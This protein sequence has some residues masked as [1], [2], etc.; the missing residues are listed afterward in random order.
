[1]AQVGDVFCDQRFSRHSAAYFLQEVV[2]TCIVNAEGV[3]LRRFAAGHVCDFCE[4][5]PIGI[6]GAEVIQPGGIEILKYE[7]IGLDVIVEL[8]VGWLGVDDEL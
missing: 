1:M 5:V 8:F 4:E 3:L 2:E 6:F 7:G